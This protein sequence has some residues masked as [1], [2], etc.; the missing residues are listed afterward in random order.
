MNNK[1]AYEMPVVEVTLFE[2]KDVILASGVD[3]YGSWSSDTYG[4]DVY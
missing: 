2:E 1:K 3:D 4:E